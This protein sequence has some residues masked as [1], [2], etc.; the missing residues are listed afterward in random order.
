MIYLK[1]EGKQAPATERE[2]VV[3]TKSYRVSN[4]DKGTRVYY[5]PGVW[6]RVGPQDWLNCFVIG[7]S[8][9][10]IDVIRQAVKEPS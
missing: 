8:G 5:E 10:T 6:A 4:D 1:F 3:C 7:E 2:F 9:K